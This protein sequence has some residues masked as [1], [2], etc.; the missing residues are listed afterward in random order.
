MTLI[1]AEQP[2]RRPSLTK[3]DLPYCNANANRCKPCTVLK[4]V[5][6]NAGA[7]PPISQ[8]PADRDNLSLG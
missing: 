1:A 7:E 3:G 2:W 4:A 5:R 6:M 8:E